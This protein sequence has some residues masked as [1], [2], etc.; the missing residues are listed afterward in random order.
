MMLKQRL[1]TKRECRASSCS[2]CI[3]GVQAQVQGGGGRELWKG[4]GMGAGTALHRHSLTRV[5]HDDIALTCEILLFIARHL[6]TNI[7]F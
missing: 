2:A 1:T 5:A 4:G 3:A 7:Y 6:H